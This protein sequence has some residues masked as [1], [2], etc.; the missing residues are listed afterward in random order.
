MSDCG[1][2]YHYPCAMAA[3]AFQVSTVNV[4]QRGT[5]FCIEH[6]QAISIF[7]QSIGKGRQEYENGLT[8][9]IK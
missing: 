2:I 5:A 4:V 9:F 1:R 8:L 3:R 6:I 7:S